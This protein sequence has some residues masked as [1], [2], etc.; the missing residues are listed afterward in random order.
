VHSLGPVAVTTCP[1]N[2]CEKLIAPPAGKA[3]VVTGIHIDVYTAP[4][5]TTSSDFMLISRSNNGT[6]SF[7]T[8]DLNYEIVDPLGRGV[9][10]LR[11][12]LPGGLP[13]PAGTAVC[14]SKT[15]G[16][17]GAE[18]TAW[19][20]SVASTAVPASAPA[21]GVVDMDRRARTDLLW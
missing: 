16:G 7:G 2:T 1:N 13:V 10:D 8:T 18:L 3:L 12:D 11:Y 15:A 4:N 14:I 17:I 21:P 5:P 20:Y 6:C 9:I 19:G